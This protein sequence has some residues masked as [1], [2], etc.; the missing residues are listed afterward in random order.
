[1]D[2]S[3]N[4]LQAPTIYTA[5]VNDKVVVGAAEIAGLSP[6][7]RNLAK[8]IVA[9]ENQNVLRFVYSPTPAAP[10]GGT[11]A[12]TTT[13]TTTVVTGNTGNRT[14][15]TGVTPGTGTAG[16]AGTDNTAGGDNTAAGQ[17]NEAV[18]EGQEQEA[19]EAAPEEPSEPQ[20]LIDLDDEEVPL[21]NGGTID[22]GI[23]AGSK[24]PA[25]AGI[26]TS[27]KIAIAGVIVAVAAICIGAA[28]MLMGKKRKK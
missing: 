6:Q 21:A 19:V 18:A 9:D 3:G 15:V 17:T 16:I 1:M 11:A 22:D 10:A 13:T 23:N 4:Q 25:E 5:N 20:E 12:T 7:A 8:T 28:Y 27:S 24:E 14:T 2:A 26:A